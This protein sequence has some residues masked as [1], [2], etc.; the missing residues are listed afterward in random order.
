[1]IHVENKIPIQAPSTQWWIIVRVQSPFFEWIAFI[2]S[3]IQSSKFVI[4]Q[5]RQELAKLMTYIANSLDIRSTI[6]A[7]LN[8]IDYI[9]IIEQDGL[10]VTKKSFVMHIL[11]LWTR[12]VYYELFIFEQ[13]QASEEIGSFLL[14][15]ATNGLQIKAE[16][17]SN[18][19]VIEL[20][21]H[22]VM[23]SCVLT[24]LS[25]R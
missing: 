14:S 17:G 7:A 4:F 9:T 6:D 15:I 5:Q 19:H 18:N 22:L 12:D 2:I 23:S 11:G 3:S 20:E 25:A 21:A 10:F 8:K 24:C 13:L 16:H 1:M